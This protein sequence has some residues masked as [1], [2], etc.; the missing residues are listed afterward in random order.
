MGVTYL[1]RVYAVFATLKATLVCN[2]KYNSS[3]LLKEKDTPP[4]ESGSYLTALESMNEVAHFLGLGLR[5]FLEKRGQL[6]HDDF[7]KFHVPLRINFLDIIDL[8]K[9]TFRKKTLNYSNY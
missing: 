4:D 3:D 1:C 5:D 9:R 8:W 7:S 2:P 6:K